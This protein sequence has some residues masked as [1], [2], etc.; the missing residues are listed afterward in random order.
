[1]EDE[2]FQHN[3]DLG[4]LVQLI[5]QIPGQIE[6]IEHD[7]SSTKSAVEL[8][9]TKLDDLISKLER[10]DFLDNPSLW[11]TGTTERNVNDS[12]FGTFP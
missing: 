11:P 9:T 12:N 10:R 5:Q 4:R 2:T 7:V 1:M 6:N 8:M 3:Q